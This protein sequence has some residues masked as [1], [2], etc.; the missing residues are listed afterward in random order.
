[1]VLGAS[2]G[3]GAA[4]AV[5]LAEAGADIVG[6][7]L[8][9]RQSRGSADATK[10]AIEALGRQAWFIR[11]NAAA[12]DDRTRVLDIIAAEIGPGALRVL[13]H[14][15][16]FGSPV[17][18]IGGGPSPRGVPFSRQLA[19]T[20]DVMASSLVYWVR[21]LVGCGF[22]G[23]GGRIIALSSHGAH[24]VLPGYGAVG[25]AKAALEASIRQ[26]AVELAPCGITANTI[27]AGLTDTAA[28]RAIP[29]AD[30]LHERLL[31]VHPAGRI[32]TPEDVAGAVVAL[33]SPACGWLTGNTISVDGGES[34]IGA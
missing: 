20:L 26:L 33:C 28:F 1:M 22:I 19:M 10:A 25:A 16:G 4:C 17:Q 8:G 9:R 24:R 29:R 18:Y 30:A 3:I 13:V 23:T 5:A 6:I 32:T 11:A 14:S 34:V 12:E 15:I 7:S 27:R 31:A 21:D 2:S